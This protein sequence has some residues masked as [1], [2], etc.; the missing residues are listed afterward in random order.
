MIAKRTGRSLGLTVVMLVVAGCL[1]PGTLQVADYRPQTPAVGATFYQCL[2]Q[3]QQP[4]A[5]SGFAAYGGIA[6]SSATA[7]VATNR[8]LVCACM[9]AA[10]YAPRATA[11]GETVMNVLFLPVE[12][13]FAL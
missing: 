7:G 5:T 13:P 2:Q 3:A 10:G 4:Y 8:Q 11:S 9:R 12:I 1:G 6:G